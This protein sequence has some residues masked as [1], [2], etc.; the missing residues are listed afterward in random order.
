MTMPSTPTLFPPLDIL[1]LGETL[2]DFLS[3]EQADSLATAVHFQRSLGGSPANVAV[4]VVRLGG[5]AAVASKVGVGAFGTFCR[6]ALRAANV[7]T[8]YL[9]MDPAVHTTVIFVTR[10]PGTPDFEAFRSG[11]SELRPEDVS[12]EALRRARVVHFSMWPL[13]REPA[14]SAVF[15]ACERALQ[16]GALLSLDPNYHPGLWYSR[17][18]ALAVL[19]DLYPR[20][21]LTKPSLDDA[22]RL[23]GPG[24]VPEG[25][26]DRFHTLGAQTVV[27]TMGAAGVWL[28]TAAGRS[29]IPPLR[30]TITNATGAGDAFW[31]GFLL[32]WLDAC[33]GH[34]CV[35]FAQEATR[36]KLTGEDAPLIAA[37]RARFY[38]AFA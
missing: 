15:S 26:I 21:T 36:R 7:S 16:H 29:F 24:D 25:Y 10:T 1:C 19:R 12:P 14:R 27:L 6:D 32:A 18:E 37:D 11:D 9:V 3:V 35:R 4:Q 22:V 30:Y 8:E 33:D 5:R 13:S 23:F 20:I 34:T 17:D 28:S 31:A 38:A 2:V